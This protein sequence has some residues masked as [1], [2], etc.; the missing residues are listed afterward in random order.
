MLSKDMG[1]WRL[2]ISAATLPPGE[3]KT[4]WN[5]SQLSQLLTRKMV[6]VFFF[7]SCLT[8]GSLCMEY[9][10]ENAL[11]LAQQGCEA[12]S[13]EYILVPSS[14]RVQGSIREDFPRWL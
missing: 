3:K 13:K 1:L 7:S 8:P 14:K 2:N 6:V 9:L 5:R 12:Q 4:A 11:L 10:L